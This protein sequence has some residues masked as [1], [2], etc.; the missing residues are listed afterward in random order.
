MHIHIFMQ[1]I[2]KYWLTFG[3]DE[4]TDNSTPS[5]VI[6]EIL[7]LKQSAYSL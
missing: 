2:G 6:I 7:T 4:I 3:T 1:F 5:F